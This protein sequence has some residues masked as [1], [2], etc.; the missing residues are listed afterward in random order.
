MHPMIFARG[1]DWLPLIGALHHVACP[2]SSATAPSEVAA[3]SS[4]HRS[5]FWWALDIN[6]LSCLEWDPTV[7]LGLEQP[8]VVEV[9]EQSSKTLD[10]FCNCR[11][12]HL[13]LHRQEVGAM[14]GLAGVL[15]EEFPSKSCLLAPIAVEVEELSYAQIVL[16]LVEAVAAIDESVCLLQWCFHQG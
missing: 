7:E 1:F 9:A 5:T 2:E 13:L 14:E 4:A 15:H 6:H 11:N 8:L 3:R 12:H 16:T 10:T